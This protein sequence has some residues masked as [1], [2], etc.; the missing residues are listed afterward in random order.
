MKL[1]LTSTVFLANSL[2]LYWLRQLALSL[3]FRKFGLIPIFVA[4]FYLL[5]F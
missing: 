5:V 3:V 4:F 1:Y 2:C